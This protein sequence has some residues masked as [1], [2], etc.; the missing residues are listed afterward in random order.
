MLQ[1][2]VGADEDWY[3]LRLQIRRH[4]GAVLGPLG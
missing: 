3:V 1:R 2:F 4:D